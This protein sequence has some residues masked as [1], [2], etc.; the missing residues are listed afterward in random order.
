MRAAAGRTDIWNGIAAA[1]HV[2]P[3]GLTGAVHLCRREAVRL[4]VTVKWTRRAATNFDLHSGPLLVLA[5]V[6]LWRLRRLLDPQ[7]FGGVD[8]SPTRGDPWIA[9]AIS[10]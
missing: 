1:R 8:S 9:L 6:L 7:P 5:I 10:S 3:H 2:L 4:G